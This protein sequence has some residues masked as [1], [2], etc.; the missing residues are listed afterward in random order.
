MTPG[1]LPIATDIS[2]PG[3]WIKT[4]GTGAGWSHEL[5]TP[6]SSPGCL[7]ACLQFIP[8]G[9]TEAF[10]EWKLICTDTLGFL[11]VGKLKIFLYQDLVTSSLKCKNRLGIVI[12]KYGHHELHYNVCSLT[13]LRWRHIYC[14]C[15]ITELSLL[16]RSCIYSICTSVCAG[17]ALHIMLP[18]RRP[19]WETWFP[20][21]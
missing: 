17:N 10:L 14:V 11:L 7:L 9:S 18:A 8:Q 3:S 2:L 1:E 5:I 15:S 12:S 20:I 6:M 4:I 16:Q 19:S 21:T 13:N